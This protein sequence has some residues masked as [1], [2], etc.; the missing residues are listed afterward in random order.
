MAAVAPRQ[1][2]ALV[3]IALSVT[4]AAAPLTNEVKPRGG[5]LALN[6]DAEAHHEDLSRHEL[7]HN[8]RGNSSLSPPPTGTLLLALALVISVLA[9]LA[10]SWM[11]GDGTDSKTMKARVRGLQVSMML[12]KMRASRDKS[13]VAALKSQL[14]REDVLQKEDDKLVAT[15]KATLVEEEGMLAAEESDVAAKE[16]KIF[17]EQ[18]ELINALNATKNDSEKAEIKK[19]QEDAKKR[20]EQCL[21]QHDDIIKR[22]EQLKRQKEISK[23][24]EGELVKQREL[25][26][27][28]EIEERRL[29]AHEAKLVSKQSQLSADSEKDKQTMASLQKQRDLIKRQQDQIK[30]E[31]EVSLK[32]QEELKQQ[33]ELSALQ[34]EKLKGLDEARSK[35]IEKILRRGNVHV[36]MQTQQIKVLKPLPFKP[37]LVTANMKAPPAAAFEDSASANAVLSDLAELLSY[38]RKAVILVEEHTSGGTLAISDIGFQIATERAELVVQMLVSKGVNA[39][40][41]EY[42]GVPGTMGDNE[43]TTKLVTLSWGYN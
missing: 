19:R 24:Q 34:R 22:Q 29:V 14:S 37:I 1:A 16:K 20:Q 4:V 30:K 3:A 18:K 8:L 39:A 13:E 43:F 23:M 9:N 15:L 32:K 33:K 11:K 42:R 27:K 38:I 26:G 35:N 31:R 28:L 6:V 41:L 2:F 12:E 21:K 7:Q 25:H 36:D 17:A 5:L 40:R 10:Q